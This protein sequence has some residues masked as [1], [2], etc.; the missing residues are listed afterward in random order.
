[1][2]YWL[3]VF[4]SYV[5]ILWTTNL[6]YIVVYKMTIYMAYTPSHSPYVTL[7][8]KTLV[9][10]FV[11][12]WS[13]PTR[14]IIFKQCSRIFKQYSYVPTKLF[15]IIIWIVHKLPFIWTLIYNLRRTT[16]YAFEIYNT[17]LHTKKMT[18]NNEPNNLQVMYK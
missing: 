16:P 6:I 8:M 1:M 10:N 5:K 2:P 9:Y 15:Y 18:I 7:H 13:R 12:I 14:L 3:I 17:L 11:R 4:A